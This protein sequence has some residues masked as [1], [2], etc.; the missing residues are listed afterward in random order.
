MTDEQIGKMVIQYIQEHD[1]IWAPE[2]RLGD[3]VDGWLPPAAEL[4][5]FVRQLVVGER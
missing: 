4:G 1:W 2:D 3:R 5:A